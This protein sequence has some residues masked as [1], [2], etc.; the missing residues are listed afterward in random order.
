MRITLI[1]LEQIIREEWCAETAWKPSAWESSKP[2]AGQCFSTSYVIQQLLGGEIVHAEVYPYHTPKQRH[3]WNRLP[4][5][6]ELDLTREQFPE[7][8]VLLPCELPEDLVWK[9]G[10]QQAV[11]LLEKVR[12]RL[13][14]GQ[15]QAE[16]AGA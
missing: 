13:S 8:Q 9:F 6:F 14:Q 1:Q 10:G 4:S 16:V 2:A 3:A 15:T 12:G 5:G 11:K 7:G